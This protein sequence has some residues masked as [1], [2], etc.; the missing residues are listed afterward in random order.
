MRIERDLKDVQMRLGEFAQVLPPGWSVA[1]YRGTFY[2]GPDECEIG[3]I[4]KQIYE[5]D[6]VPT[7]CRMAPFVIGRKGRRNV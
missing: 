4:L 2:I 7:G 6:Q 3:L 1:A 5:R